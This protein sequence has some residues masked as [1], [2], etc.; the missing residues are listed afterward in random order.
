MFA[1]QMSN[2]FVIGTVAFPDKICAPHL[3]CLC[4]FLCAIVLICSNHTMLHSRIN[5]VQYIQGLSHF[6]STKKVTSSPHQ[7]YMYVGQQRSQNTTH[8]FL[9]SA[10]L[11]ACFLFICVRT[12]NGPVVNF[13]G[14]SQFQKVVFDVLP[15][16]KSV[17]LSHLL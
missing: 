1:I 17:L 11:P 4:K 16:S 8:S 12:G 6:P 14:T 3:V 15:L 10:K 13:L 2:L 7:Q 5:P 9:P